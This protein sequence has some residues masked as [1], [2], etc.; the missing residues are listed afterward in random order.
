M[1]RVPTQIPTSIR[2][3]SKTFIM[4]RIWKWL[5][6]NSRWLRRG[7]WLIFPKHLQN[8]ILAGVFDDQ[9]LRIRPANTELR[10]LSSS[11]DDHFAEAFLDELQTWEKEELRVFST[12]I[13]PESV[14][15]DVGAYS[16]V[17]TLV[18]AANGA[19]RVIAI[20]PNPHMSSKLVE[21]IRLNVFES[22]AAVHQTAVGQQS[23]SGS[24]I[25]P[26]GRPRSSGARLSVSGLGGFGGQSE[27]QAV[28][29]T[30]VDKI[31]AFEGL[32]RL[33]VIK[34]DAEGFELEVLRG[35]KDSVT[36]F[37][38]II[39]CEILDKEALKEVQEEVSR[40]GYGSAIALEPT[41]SALEGEHS[42]SAVP[43][44]RNFLFLPAK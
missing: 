39:L 11:K 16:G 7:I 24:L 17:Y 20:E 9:L 31:V 29:I 4:S 1:F 26:S 33:D 42:G 21:N 35:S 36:K 28:K 25:T 23:G 44:N 6:Y 43:T 3:V 27:S 18:A 30:T 15:L 14:V 37:A 34:I 10:F 22:V 41:G 5:L 38:P 40:L 32:D 8:Y 13:R 19:R 2:R 12:Y